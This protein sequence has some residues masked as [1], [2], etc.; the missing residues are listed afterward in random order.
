MVSFVTGGIFTSARNNL[1]IDPGASRSVRRHFAARF[2][3]GRSGESLVVPQRHS[4]A[5]RLIQR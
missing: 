2:A 4:V 3:S 1:E 5:R